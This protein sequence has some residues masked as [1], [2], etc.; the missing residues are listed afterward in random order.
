MT[1]PRRSEAGIWA[2][3]R[4]RGVYPHQLAFLLQLPFRE[5]VLSRLQLVERLD[6]RPD[7]QVLEIGPGPG[8]FSAAVGRAVPRGRLELLDL[9]LPMLRKARRRVRRAELA[10]V[11]LACGSASALPYRAGSFDVVFLVAVLGEVDRPGDC[12]GEVARVLRPGGLL[13]ITELPGDPDALPRPA[14][15]ALLDPHG[16]RACGCAPLR[17]GFTLAARAAGGA[18][19]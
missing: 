10:H 17:G 13:S 14:V 1:A 5:R 4:G 7:S 2:R 19:A 9:Q 3:L 18:G 11:H 8:F 16:L 12:A 6:L 15:E